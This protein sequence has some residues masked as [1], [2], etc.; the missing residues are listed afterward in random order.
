MAHLLADLPLWG[1]FVGTLLLVLA[2]VE[3]GYRLARQR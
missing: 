3:V 2:S 1:I